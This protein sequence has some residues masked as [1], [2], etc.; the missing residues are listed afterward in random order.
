MTTAVSYPHIMKAEGKSARL[1]RQPRIR[2]AQIVVNYRDLGNSAD[3][4][5]VHYPHLT[6]AEVH[7]ALAYY[8][9]HQAEIDAEIAEEQRMIDESYKNAQ[10]TQ[11]ELK[12]RAQ[13]L[14]PPRT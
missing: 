12:L 13:G 3:D 11:V 14:L 8:F 4:V 9:D 6:L 2:V 7:S 10:P 5:C 1:E